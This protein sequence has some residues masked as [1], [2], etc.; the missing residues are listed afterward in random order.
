MNFKIRGNVFQVPHTLIYYENLGFGWAE[1]IGN[2]PGITDN[3]RYIVGRSDGSK[4]LF[5]QS[6]E[7]KGINSER[8]TADIAEGV[9]QVYMTFNRELKQE[10]ERRFSQ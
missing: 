7:F 2:L 9:K 5:I 3:H 4:T 6:D 8:T 10:V 1:E